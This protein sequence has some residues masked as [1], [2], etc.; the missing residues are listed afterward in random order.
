MKQ[1]GLKLAVAVLLTGLSLP[2]AAN[3]A[4]EELQKKVDQL[5]KEIELL[6]AR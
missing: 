6:K 5:S 1:R 2:L 4:D 3:A